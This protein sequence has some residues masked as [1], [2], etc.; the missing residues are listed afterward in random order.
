MQR[1]PEFRRPVLWLGVAGLLAFGL[2][3][4]P[5]NSPFVVGAPTKEEAAKP[6]AITISPPPADIN[7]LS[8]EVAALR[9]LYLLKASP[10][11][12]GG[13][14]ANLGSIKAH[15]KDCAQ[16]PRQRQVAEVSKNY[17]KV[18]TDLRA[19]FIA[20]QDERINELSDQLE[21]LTKEEQPD[22]DD[23]IEIT[24]LARKNGPLCLRSFDA[25]RIAEY[26][27]AYGKDF[28]DP[29]FLM[30]KTARADGK[31]K[32][33]PPELWKETRAFVI[34]EVSWQVAGLDLK[35]QEKIGE[36][37]ASVLDRAYAL[38]DD[39]VRKQFAQAG[40]GLRGEIGYIAG[41]GGG[42][43]DIIKHVVEQ[44]FAELLSNPRLLPAIRAREDY[45]KKAA[46]ASR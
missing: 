4:V 25:G 27:A 8:M 14:P 15:S 44:D 22:L 7:D 38:S 41:Q 31:G 26:I 24:D 1:I 30:F 28:P 37:V 36:Q 33:E 16:A 23:A 6:S 18:L 32:K 13:R 43:T 17:R 12:T 20:G 19:A 35:K 5:W 11:Q 39:E 45:L 29:F 2:I 40:K 10:D 9:T 46:E 3:S 21:E 42:P 34:K